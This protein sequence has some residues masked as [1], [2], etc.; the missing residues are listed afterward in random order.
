MRGRNHGV[1]NDQHPPRIVPLQPDA[2]WGFFCSSYMAM[3]N[4]PNSSRNPWG[5]MHAG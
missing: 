3:H 5:A 2:I 4:G 1:A